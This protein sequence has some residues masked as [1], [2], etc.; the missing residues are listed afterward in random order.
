MPKL[1]I[2]EYVDVMEEDDYS[3]Y[4]NGRKRY[5]VDLIRVAD[6]ITTILEKEDPN[7]DIEITGV[8]RWE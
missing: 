1:E 8:A 4:N 6:D 7:V 3:T 2:D 5:F